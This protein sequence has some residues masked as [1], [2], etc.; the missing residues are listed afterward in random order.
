MFVSNHRVWFILMVRKATE[1]S[2]LL[3]F[4]DTH[5]QTLLQM[6]MREEKAW[7]WVNF[8]SKKYALKTI[9]YMTQKFHQ[10][11]H[12]YFCTIK[13]LWKWTI[14]AESP[15]WFEPEW[16]RHKVRQ[17]HPWPCPFCHYSN[18]CFETILTFGPLWPALPGC[19]AGPW[20]RGQ[21]K[22][23][24]GNSIII[25]Q[26]KYHHD[27]KPSTYF[28]PFFSQSSH[29]TRKPIRSLGGK[30]RIDLLCVHYIFNIWFTFI[31][32]SSPLAP[33]ALE[34]LA[35]PV[36]PVYPKKRGSMTPNACCAIWVRII[37]W[38]FYWSAMIC[39][40]PSLREY[41]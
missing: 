35:V 3:S 16:P 24:E 1:I 13:L 17:W 5:V 18:I 7:K 29:W 41:Q 2:R 39:S 33:V 8:F 10:N 26:R 37:H 19:P 6:S 40:V 28:F 14:Q 36:L 22:N 25:F 23:I 4:W 38:Y 32:F 12:I 27:V 11:H 31:Q 15:C 34:I 9:W 21:K 20:F 30:R